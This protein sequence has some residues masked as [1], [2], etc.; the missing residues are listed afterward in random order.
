MKILLKLTSHLVSSELCVII[1]L[2]LHYLEGNSLSQHAFCFHLSI[3]TPVSLCEYDACFDRL[4]FHT[5]NPPFDPLWQ[6]LSWLS[7]QQ[8]WKGCWCVSSS[9][10]LFCSA[11]LN[12][13][14]FY[15]C[16][17]FE[18]LHLTHSQLCLDSCYCLF[19]GHNTQY[20]TSGPYLLLPLAEHTGHL[21]CHL[22]S[23]QTSFFDAT[24]EIGW[25][26]TSPAPKI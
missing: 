6:L 21:L 2:P 23:L 14:R 20:F 26:V 25:E 24:N 4:H 3:C 10:S 18:F 19:S 8:M 17:D 5:T 7:W 13:A 15:F 1:A 11:P 22:T 16:C 12:V 9:V